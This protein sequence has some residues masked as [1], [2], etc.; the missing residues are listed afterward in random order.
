MLLLNNPFRLLLLH[1]AYLHTLVFGS[2]WSIMFKTYIGYLKHG[3]VAISTEP[4]KWRHVRI[5]DWNV[6]LNWSNFCR[7]FLCFQDRN[8]WYVISDNLYPNTRFQL[9]CTM[10][11]YRYFWWLG[12][13][14][15]R[16]TDK[17]KA[18]H[19]MKDCEGISFLSILWTCFSQSQD[20]MK[21]VRDLFENLQEYHEQ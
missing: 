8:D 12:Y 10:R 7:Q 2:I 4:R 9:N 13:F 19:V 5:G 20:I 17:H 15:H 11:S 21:G 6:S 3:F 16:E 1:T 14:C 18:L